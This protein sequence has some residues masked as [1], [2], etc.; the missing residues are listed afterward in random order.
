MERKQ[1]S[2]NEMDYSYRKLAVT[3]KRKKGKADRVKGRF[4]FRRGL[5]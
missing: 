5:T 4:L 2:K 3:E 1:Y